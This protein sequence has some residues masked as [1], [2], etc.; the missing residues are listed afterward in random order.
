MQLSEIPP[1]RATHW[2][3]ENKQCR[4]PKRWIA[5]D[6]ES[7]SKHQGGKETQ[8]WSMGAAIRWREDLK[9]GD[10]AEA[11]T[12]TD[13]L[14][15]WQWVTDFCKPGQRTVAMAH[16]LGYDVR[17]TQALEILPKLGW[18]LEWCNLDR[19]VSAMTWRSD[20][21][22]LVFADTWTWIPT[23]LAN[24]ASSVGLKKLPMP[25]DTAKHY[26]WERYC[27]RDA[28]IVY[29]V[30][31]DLIGFIRS[32]NLGNWQPTGAGM[33][34]ATW[35]HKFLTHKI[36]VHDD[37]EALTAERAAMHTG[38]AEAWKH[39]EL[40]HTTWT[41]VDM[42]NAYVT[43]CADS[44]L[45]VKLKYHLGALSESQYHTLS[46]HYRVLCRCRVTTS[47]PV[48][49][50]FDGNRSLWPVGTFD[51]WLWDTEVD[52]LLSESAQVSIRESF[53]Y[54]RAK[55]LSAWAIWVLSVLRSDNNGASSA[56]QTWIKHCSRALIGRLALRHVKWELFG[57]NPEGFTCITRATNAETGRTKRYMHVGNR[58]FEE[59]GLIEGKDSLPQITGWIMAECRMRLW[60]AMRAAGLD[61]IA[62]VDTDSLLVSR[63]GY[64]ALRAAC[65]AAWPDTWQV[66]GSARRVIVYGP[67]NYRWGKARKVAGVPRKAHEILPNVFDGEQWQSVSS[68]L[69]EGAS[70]T[71]AIAQTRWRLTVSDPRREHVSGGHTCAVEIQPDVCSARTSSSSG[72]PGMGA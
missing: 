72:M 45:P 66:K 26:R 18:R 20:K 52:M 5:F 31:K 40:S 8:S 71:V 32:E 23:A 7:W 9:T 11:A 67:R 50:Y 13:T 36:L 24:I 58:T 19:N 54:S 10:S 38:R 27:M 65:G 64:E 47:L 2:I 37:V 4:I 51:T 33:A 30:V 69:T 62:H 61:E 59:S 46:A 39:G 14:E 25:P 28:E 41:E 55:I 56:C 60:H 17:I 63:R 44:D 12:F 21:G 6:S 70:S 16:N 57:E 53:V 43:I 3:R 34:Y 48:V 22:T 29:R 68:G 1:D 15:L 42:R 35:R 49:P